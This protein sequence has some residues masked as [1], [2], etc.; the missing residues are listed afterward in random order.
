MEFKPPKGLSLTGD[1]AQNWT[2]FKQKFMIFLD[3]NE[4]N[5]KPDDVKIAMF[6]NAVG[7]EG[8][9]LFNTFTLTAEEKKSFQHVLQAFE[10]YSTPRK[11]TVLNRYKFFVR[12]QQEGETFDHFQIELKRLA[13]IC[14]FGDQTNSLIRDRIIIGVKDNVLQ[15]RLL[16]EGDLTLKK[17]IDLCQAYEASK[18]EAKTLQ[19]SSSDSVN[20]VKSE[21]PKTG[22]N[23]KY[24]F[25][26]KN[27]KTMHGINECPAFGKKCHQCFKMNHFKVAC[28]SKNFT[29]KKQKQSHKMVHEL[30][31]NEREEENEDIPLSID[32]LTTD[33]AKG[34]WYHTVQINNHEVVCKMDSGSDVDVLPYSKYLQV[35]PDS[36][37]LPYRSKIKAYNGSYV[38]V[39]GVVKL[40]CI[41]ERRNPVLLEFVVVETESQPLLGLKTCLKLKLMSK[42]DQVEVISNSD[43]RE[44]FIRKNSRVFTGLGKIPFEYKIQLK[45]DAVP[46]IKPVR[47]V[48][49]AIK[50]KLRETL[51]RME[52]L[53]IITEVTKPTDWVNDLIIVE[54]RDGS[55][56]LCLSPLELNKYVKREVFQI[57]TVEDLTAN[58]S[59]KSVFT[60]LDW[61]DGFLHI[62][63]EETST[64]LCVFNTPFGRYKFERLPFGLVS[65]PEVFQR[66]N[67]KIFGDIPGVQVYFDD[68]IISARNE[69]EHD[70]ILNKVVSRALEYNVRFNPVKMQYKVSQVTYLG[71]VFSKEGLQ[72]DKKHVESIHKLEEPKNKKSLQKFLGII[73]YLH[74]FIPHMSTIT[75]PLRE[76]LKKDVP[77]SWTAEHQSAF[78]DLKT[79][80]ANS[81]TLKFFNP[82]E[83]IILQ[84]DASKDGLGAC[85]MQQGRPV[86]FVS[87]SLTPSEQRYSMVEK[88]LLGICFA[89]QKFH[90]FIYGHNVIC[91][92]D[93][94]P[95]VSIVKKDIHKST[96]RIQRLLLKLLKYR[97]D[98]RYLP[99]KLMYISDFLSRNYVKSKVTDDPDMLDVVHVVMLEDYLPV[100]KPKLLLLQNETKND[101][102]LSKVIDCVINGNWVNCMKENV[103]QLSGLKHYFRLK[104]HLFVKDNI[105]FLNDKV[106]VPSSLYGEML[107][108][109]HGDA[110][111]G[112]NKSKTRARSLLYW[113]NMS[114]MIE[115]FVKKCELCE[116][117]QRSN[118]KEPLISH[119]IPTLPFYK[120]GI[121]IAEFAS[122]SYLIAVDY[123]SKWLEIIPLTNK[124]ADE[125]II[126]L[127]MLFSS[128][129]IPHTIVCDNNPFNSYK[130][131]KF[132][133]DYNFTIV[134]SSPYHHQS[135]GLCEKGVG[136][137]KGI[138]KKCKDIGEMYDALLV[139][140]TSPVAGLKY[141]PAEI[142]MGRSL[143]TQI[144]TVVT[145]LEPKLVYKDARSQL[146]SS[147][148]VS[149][150]YYDRTAR[151][152]LPF[153]PGQS[154]RIQNP[155]TKLWQAGKVVNANTT[156]RTYKVQT[157]SDRR[158]NRNSVFIRK[159]LNQPTIVGEPLED[160]HTNKGENSSLPETDDEQVLNHSSVDTKSRDSEHFNSASSNNG[161][162]LL[163]H[164]G[165]EVRTRSGRVISKPARFKDYV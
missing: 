137:A 127:K 138:L 13:Q 42:V 87:R 161:G 113:P 112:I 116:T 91:Q 140:R 58:M 46:V 159:S 28:R 129:G 117:Y 50:P 15:E 145:H 151:N 27:C 150:A 40:M 79:L 29:A 107:R 56:R 19:H 70:E 65:S 106:I 162:G 142:L 131:K 12:S 134:H 157:E 128:F 103:N 37:L 34:D 164:G 30:N 92:T 39:K 120:I 21:R 33:R 41:P 7:D 96:N 121:D 153:A 75:A 45:K 84:T 9:Q 4:Y 69:D 72:P 97:L 32:R 11:S 22:G 73:T 5:K 67:M 38:E 143:R 132:S 36:E 101:V 135:N 2:I 80:V 155:I 125:I 8:L 110:H 158:Y 25:Q 123:L 130:F 35:C 81:P 94:K 26:C 63:L 139:Y 100:S 52:K 102:L 154:V 61:K 141:S 51:N 95:L 90:Q 109:I 93:H 76:L 85:L 156:P 62:P 3:A 165:D 83:Q 17:T 44:E 57:P 86:A 23:T 49:E 119:D 54:K 6:L 55:L 53:G 163:K 24:K 108:Q 147:K 152:R 146:L 104:D 48:P 148:S 77:W 16:R 43:N 118:T 18:N 88:E 60:V 89:V 149:K 133:D 122:N 82:S 114:T 99:G 160:Y 47:R 1:V 71:L 144:P 98:V 59:G 10:N 64:Y 14:E 20:Y 124:T 68:L 31:T 111:I 105:L 78:E 126:K 136:I 74:K 115:N 66:E